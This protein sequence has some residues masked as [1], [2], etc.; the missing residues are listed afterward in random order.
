MKIAVV[1]AGANGCFISYYLS[2]DGHQVILVEKEDEPVTSVNNAGLLTPELSPSPPV[3][4]GKLARASLIPSG[5]LY[6]SLKQIL[7]NPGWVSAALHGI[8]EERKEALVRF[9]RYSLQL[10]EEF[11]DRENCRETVSYRKGII[12][13][14][15][16]EGMGQISAQ[17][18]EKL[19]Y[20]GFGSGH[21]LH[22]EISID[23]HKLMQTLLSILGSFP[24]VSITRAEVTGFLTEGRRVKSL[25]TSNG[26][27]EADAYV[28]ATGS[29]TQQLCMSI[30][31]DAR[32]LPARGLVMLFDTGGK[33]V[34]GSPAMLEDYGAAI[35]QHKNN[36]LRATTFFELNGFKSFSKSR[37]EWLVGILRRHV[38]E[39]PSLKLAYEG[40]GFRP[41]TPD[42]LPLIGKIPNFDNLYLAAGHCRVGMTLAASTGKLISD[43]IAEKTVDER[44]VTVFDPSRFLKQ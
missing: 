30:G 15:K 38:S 21:Y 16:S 23:S 36:V 44:F 14:Y 18:I 37:S 29:Y 27:I 31:F 35:A 28:L 19:G 3:S 43:M 9:G 1:G 8:D 39:F 12:A 26:K 5:P 40:T 4:M 11:F 32:I 22:E 17:D 24:N 25:L 13:L 33:Q 20:R 10:F 7:R 2:K 6:F 34:V 42:Q 41:C